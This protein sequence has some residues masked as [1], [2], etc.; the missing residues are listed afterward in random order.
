MSLA[1]ISHDEFAAALDAQNALIRRDL[2]LLR[3]DQR[4]RRKRRRLEVVC[5]NCQQPV[6][7]VI[8]T[9]TWTVVTFREAKADPTRPT[10]RTTEDRIESM[11]TSGPRRSEIRRGEAK[12][13][14]IPTPVLDNSVGSFVDAL[15]DCYRHRVQGDTLTTALR[16]GTRKMTLRPATL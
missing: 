4:L 15:C 8:V 6:I 7:E 2:A 9:S 14:P 1:D 10:F 5:T 3:G 12:F 11:K 16:A 13:F